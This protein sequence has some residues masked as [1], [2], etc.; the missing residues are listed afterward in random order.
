[1][2]KLRRHLLGPEGQTHC[3]HVISRFAGRHI[4]FGAPEREFFRTLLTRQLRFSGLRCLAWCCLGNHFHLL[5]E[6]PD[7]LQATQGWSQEDFLNRLHL[8]S[9]EAHSRKLL[10]EIAQCRK[11]AD[12]QRLSEIA[13][14]LRQR[15][16]DLSRF[17]QEF[18]HKFSLW[19]NQR[20][21][22]CGIVW[23]ERF[24]SLLVEGEGCG[25]EGPG[26][27]A[28]VAAYIDLNPVRA[29]LVKDPAEYR[30]SSYGEAV[31]GKAEA[32]EGLARCMGVERAVEE[33]EE[34][35]GAEKRRSVKH[36][37]KRGVKADARGDGIAEEEEERRLERV[38]KLWKGVAR[39]Y[40]VLL[41]VEGEERPG[42]MTP[43][44]ME[45]G[46]RGFSREEVEAVLA[47]GGR[48]PLAVALRCR[49][50]YFTEG[51]ALGSTRYLEEFFAARREL[52]G[53]KRTSAAREMRGAEWGELR[54]IREF[55]G[56]GISVT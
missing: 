16:F 11:E 29:G 35:L 33:K 46:R 47:S 15:L 20:H 22:R 8:L 26:G 45:P 23:E 38:S 56:N 2:R 42:G 51:L 24:K 12:H 50:R 18:K 28:A 40:R 32:R 31:A 17:M 3:Y 55:R 44:G 1:M 48:L 19:F 21:G 4:V 5:L 10:T 7:K 9:E 53:A 27:L 30:W 49:V 41:Y 54:S 13:E 39:Q 37:V 14:S 52:F 34:A 6:V 36:A 43:E 25:A